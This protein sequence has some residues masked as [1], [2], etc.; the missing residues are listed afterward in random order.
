MAYSLLWLSI[1]VA[2]GHVRRQTETCFAS[3]SATE[4]ALSEKD[5]EMNSAPP[6]S[7]HIKRARERALAYAV[8]GDLYLAVSSYTADLMRHREVQTLDA[9]WLLQ[10]VTAAKS[11]DASSVKLWINSDP[12]IA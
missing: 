8:D 7:E 3:P 12:Q 1:R 5:R 6:L 10:G 4:R 11:K 2:E 9:A